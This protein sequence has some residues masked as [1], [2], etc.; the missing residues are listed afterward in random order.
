MSTLTSYIGPLGI[1]PV[2]EDQLNRWKEGDTVV[3]CVLH[4][5]LGH[6]RRSRVIIDALIQKK[7]HVVIASSG[8]AA[9][10]L[11]TQYPNCTYLPLADYR[12]EYPYSRIVLNM[13]ASLPHIVYAVIKE[14]KIID[15]FVSSHQVQGII[16]DNRL[17]CYHHAV[18]CMYISHQIKI[19]H[20]YKFIAYMGSK[21]HQYFIKKFNTLWIPDTE[22]RNLCGYM[23]EVDFN[24]PH[25]YIGILS[26]IFPRPSITKNNTVLCILS[27]PEPQRSHFEKALFHVFQERRELQFI[28]IRGSLSASEAPHLDHVN[29]IDLADTPTITSLLQ[30]CP[31]LIARSGYTTILDTYFIDIQFIMIPTPGQTE[32]EYLSTYLKDDKKYSVAYQDRPD[33]IVEVLDEVYNRRNTV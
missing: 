7:V 23:G 8:L 33:M 18:P 14:K 11:K 26:D 17:G 19:I 5:G 25:R 3:Y 10:W 1:S 30:S 31:V 2:L 21:V 15:H 20:P 28:L 4:W 32:Q 9:T 22:D 29:V 13:I 12:I 27:G 6:A 16:S 24:H